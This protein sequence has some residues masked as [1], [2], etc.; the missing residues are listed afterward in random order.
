M[1]LIRQLNTYVTIFIKQQCCCILTAISILHH[2]VHPATLWQNHHYT[3]E[4]T[5]QH[6]IPCSERCPDFFDDILWHPL[7]SNNFAPKCIGVKIM[8]QISLR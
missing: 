5:D 4:T 8:A 2:N 7:T 1:P 6:K 3:G